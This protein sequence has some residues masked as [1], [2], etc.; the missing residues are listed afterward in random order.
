M[1]KIVEKEL[2]IIGSGPAGL[3]AGMVA[4]KYKIDYLIVEAGNIAQ[5]WRNV[6]PDMML[7]SPNHPQRDWT[8]LSAK[9]PIW[10]MDTQ[11]PYC[12]AHEFVNYLDAF[13]DH[14]KLNLSLH[15][16]VAEIV[17][18]KSG[19][20]CKSVKNELYHAPLLL[21]ATGIFGNPWFP[22]V[23]GIAGNE[24]VIHSDNYKGRT[25]YKN[26]KV[27]IIG[28]GNSAA[29]IAIDLAGTAM[30][31]LVTRDELKFFSDS[32][33][34]HHIR[35]ISE[36]YLK[37]LIAMEII[38]YHPFKE[39]EKIDQNEVSFGDWQESFD[40]IIF[41]TGYQA[42]LK[43]L[44]NF[45]IGVNKNKFPEVSVVGE[46]IQ[47]PGMFFGGPLAFHNPASIVMHGF[48][49]QIPVTIRR[50]AEVLKKL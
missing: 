11:R 15:D 22:P 14:F 36:S 10:K 32:K 6:R 9:F 28:G 39:I 3:K 8:S 18:Q 30:V 20:L 25:G 27:L 47:Y 23:A 29:E 49:K 45:N 35:G 1:Q 42:N 50:I 41:A 43:V 7:L 13:T 4:A 40:K 31:F 37:E 26:K 34:L 24:F 5:A 17:K 2:I 38:R 16:G 19:W 44:N 48:G 21:I 33:K 12:S 46:S